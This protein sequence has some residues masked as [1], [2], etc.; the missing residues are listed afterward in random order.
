MKKLLL[1]VALAVLVLGCDI[2]EYY[3]VV[4]TNSSEKNVTFVYND[5]T[6][7]IPAGENKTYAVKA[8]TQSPKNYVDQNGIASVDMKY[9]GITGDYTFIDREFY[10]LIVTNEFPFDVTFSAGNFI[11]NGGLKSITVNT[12]STNTGSIIYT[13]KPKFTPALSWP[14]VFEWRIIVLD[15]LDHLG[16]P[17]KNMNVTIR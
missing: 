13:D 16:K 9:N 2:K 1:I 8:Y 7:T 6:D 4:I 5:S 15:E 14:L 12:G 3:D 10:N 11:D 17:K